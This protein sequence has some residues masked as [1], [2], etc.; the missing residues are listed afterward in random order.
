MKKIVFLFVCLFCFLSIGY[1]KTINHSYADASGNIIFKDDVYGTSA[2]AGQNVDVSGNVFG[3]NFLAGL[4]VDYKGQSDYLCVA[5]NNIDIKGSVVYDGFIAG[6]IVDIDK[7][8]SINRDVLIAGSDIEISGNI[9]RNATIYGARVVI[10][11]A[12]ILGNVR[13]VAEDISVD[14]N[15][16]IGGKLS[17]PKDAKVSISS[18]IKNIV[19]TG[20][21]KN[22]NKETF[23]DIFASKLMSFLSLVFIFTVLTL[24]VPKLFN[25]INKKYENIDFN[26]GTEVFSKGLVFMIVGPIIC[27]LLLMI[28]FGVSLSLILLIL[29]FIILYLSKVFSGYLIGYKI[30]QKFN[31][32]NNLVMGII[33]FVVLFAFDLIPIIGGISLMLSVLFGCGIMV[34]LF[35]DFKRR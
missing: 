2:L 35:L 28:P 26:M 24:V 23:L 22:D 15:S 9:G 31:I 16:F 3:V 27:L 10:K 30:G 18:N 7:K 19:K 32:N 17:Y 11:D 5:G 13:I 33:G 14:N 21:I 20:S 8:A 34:N 6:N 12:Y 25:K 4:D 29:Y 1:A